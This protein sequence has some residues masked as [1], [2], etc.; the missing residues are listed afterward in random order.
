MTR[1]SVTHKRIRNRSGQSLIEY[2]LLV[3]LVSTLS[4][5]FARFMGRGVMQSGLK[6]LPLKVSP[7][8]STG[9]SGCD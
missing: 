8:L 6:T 2:V 4:I 1:V 7:C 9:V 5:A 3:A